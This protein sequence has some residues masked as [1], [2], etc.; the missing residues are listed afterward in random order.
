MKT[1]PLYLLAAVAEIAGCYAFWAW[2]RLDKSI[3]WLIPG[4]GS[5]MLFASAL[6]FVPGEAAGRTYAA[7]GAIYIVAS[8]VWLWTVEARMPDRWD[9]IGAAV[10]LVGGA[11]ILFGPRSA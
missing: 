9:V 7:Y 11:I 10:C 6:A 4:L 5:M 8:I 3:W 2:W 1:Y